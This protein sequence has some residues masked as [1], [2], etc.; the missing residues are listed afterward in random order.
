MCWLL[1]ST[2]TC[3]I[4]HVCVN[5]VF[6]VDELCLM[7]PCAIALQQLFNICY[8]YS[9]IVDLNCNAQKSFCFAFTPRLFKLTLPL[10]H[11]NNIL[12]SYIDPVMY[13]GFT[14]ACAHKD[15]NDMLRQM[16]TLYARSNRLLRIFHSCNTNVLNELERSYC[17]L[18]LL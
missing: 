7:A 11:F 4:N 8:S 3:Y 6:Y 13:L 5:D 12:I 10:L 17:G 14:F 18:F 9:F 16:R 15:D 1:T 2:S